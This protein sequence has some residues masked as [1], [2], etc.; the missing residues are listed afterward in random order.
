MGRSQDDLDAY[1]AERTG[2]DPDLPALIDVA[3]RR[4][5]LLRALADEGRARGLSSGP[6]P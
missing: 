1:I 6:A 2:D 5:E 3:L 4:R